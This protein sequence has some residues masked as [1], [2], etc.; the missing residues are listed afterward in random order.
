MTPAWTLLPFIKGEKK[1]TL[2]RYGCSKIKR[3][4]LSYQPAVAGLSLLTNQSTY[5]QDDSVSLKKISQLVQESSS[6]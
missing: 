5:C 1:N 4:E 2:G 6:A 3:L